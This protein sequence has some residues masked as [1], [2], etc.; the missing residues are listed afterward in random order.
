MEGP[1]KD[2]VDLEQVFL[3]EKSFTFPSDQL[4]RLHDHTGM[5]RLRTC[6]LKIEQF[7]FNWELYSDLDPFRAGDW[8]GL[9]RELS[10]K[11]KKLSIWSAQFDAMI[12]EQWLKWC[13]HKQR[14]SV[15][16]SAIPRIPSLTGTPP[17]WRCFRSKKRYK[18]VSECDDLCFWQ[19]KETKAILSMA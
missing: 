17:T 11:G 3:G 7:R 14:P 5:H 9:R 19:P 8:N 4:G 13:Q 6:D 1:N 18:K 10:E 12:N 16:K 2:E 15:K